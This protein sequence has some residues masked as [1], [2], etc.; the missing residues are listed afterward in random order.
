MLLKAALH[1]NGVRVFDKKSGRS[2]MVAS[3]LGSA[4]PHEDERASATLGFLLRPLES[5]SGTLLK[6]HGLGA[7]LVAECPD[8]LSSSTNRPAI[9][10][11]GLAGSPGVL[12]QSALS[13]P[14]G[15]F[16]IDR[17]Q[18]ACQLR[19]GYLSNELIRVGVV[20]QGIARR[21]L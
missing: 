4:I 13:D 8:D 5:R 1:E 20:A 11:S 3:A 15:S 12:G 18:S 9:A 2:R 14:P 16:A 19:L 7:A 10:T 17:P 6:A 21:E